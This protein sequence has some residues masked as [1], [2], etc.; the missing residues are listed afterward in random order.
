[1]LRITAHTS[2]QG[3]VCERTQLNET[4][5][6][7]IGSLPSKQELYAQIAAAINRAGAEAI[8][9]R[10][11][12]ILGD[13]EKSEEDLA[14]TLEQFSEKMRLASVDSAAASS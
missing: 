1:M 7:E 13:G 9:V 4:E 11:Q 2:F 12:S 10:L 5:V 14:L 6:A 8:A 3:G